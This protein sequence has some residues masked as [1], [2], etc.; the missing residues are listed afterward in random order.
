MQVN[1]DD[2]LDR[3]QAWVEED[4]L[5]IVP[6]PDNKSA[7]ISSSDQSMSYGVKYRCK[8]PYKSYNY[9]KNANG[10]NYKQC[11]RSNSKVFDNRQ[12]VKDKNKKGDYNKSNLPKKARR[13]NAVDYGKCGP[14]T[15]RNVKEHTKLQPTVSKPVLFVNFQYLTYVISFLSS[16]YGVYWCCEDRKAIS[17]ITYSYR[18]Q[19]MI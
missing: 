12:Q 7:V 13:R 16:Q 1:V 2:N 4:S 9:T 14:K 5:A 6:Y 8:K 15:R 19:I 3:T 17:N 11:K 10:Q 18:W